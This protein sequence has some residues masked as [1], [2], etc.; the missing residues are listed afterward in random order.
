MTE[1]MR[2]PHS[3]RPSLF[4]WMESG[5]PISERVAELTGQAIRVEEFSREGRLVVRA[6]LPGIDPDKDVEILIQDG[7]LR[8]QAERREEQRTQTGQGYRS[9]FRY[10]SFTRTLQLPAGV[11]EGDITAS[12]RDGILEITAPLPTPK[13][14]A[15]K[16]TVQRPDAN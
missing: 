2:R 9:E 4:D 7:R 10:G 11:Q 15:G 8:I 12:Y 13:T 5:M 1:L 6:E 16:V 14:E 3:G